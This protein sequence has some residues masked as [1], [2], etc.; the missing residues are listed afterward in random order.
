MSDRHPPTSGKSRIT[1][2]NITKRVWAMGSAT[3]NSDIIFH[4]LEVHVGHRLSASGILRM[5]TTRQ[6]LIAHPCIRSTTER[7]TVVSEELWP[8]VLSSDQN[9]V[10]QSVQSR[11]STS[12]GS[13]YSLDQRCEGDHFIS[14]HGADHSKLR[15]SQTTGNRMKR[16]PKWQAPDIPLPLSNTFKKNNWEI[17]SGVAG[18]W[19]GLP[20]RGERSSQACHRHALPR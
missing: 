11:Q 7:A 16:G 14:H 15:I 4:P 12:V 3:R 10:I 18:L 6:R 9:G 5:D 13:T 20:Y 19:H 8:R 1:A 17:L 2:L